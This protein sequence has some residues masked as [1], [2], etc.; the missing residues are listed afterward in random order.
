M[1]S[2]ESS[3]SLL[4]LNFF[5]LS[6][7]LIL[8]LLFLLSCFL[9][10]FF[11]RK[12]SSFGCKIFLNNIFPIGIWAVFSKL[13]LWEREDFLCQSLFELIRHE[14]FSSDIKSIPTIESLNLFKCLSWL[15]QVNDLH[16]LSDLNCITWQDNCF[17]EIWSHDLG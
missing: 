17:L 10:L 13:E 5:N 9:L 6:D 1:D 4:N 7:I 11:E 12:D 16:I 2:L 8:F 3:D 14:D 15:Q